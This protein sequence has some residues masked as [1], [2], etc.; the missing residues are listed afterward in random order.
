MQIL[1]A[2]EEKMKCCD[3]QEELF[4]LKNRITNL[5]NRLNSTN[6]MIFSKDMAKLM[7]EEFH[8]KQWSS[9]EYLEDYDNA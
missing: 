9:T 3:S 4:E 6:Y 8:E 2:G 5:I 1:K 7:L